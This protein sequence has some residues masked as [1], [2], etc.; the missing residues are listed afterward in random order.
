MLE[1]LYSWKPPKALPHPYL[2]F[3]EHDIPRL[4][5]KA[6]RILGDLGKYSD[7]VKKAI[8][9]ALKEV[10]YAREYAHY[11]L[12]AAFLY[13]LTGNVELADLSLKLV[14]PILKEDWVLPPHRPLKVDLGVAG[15]AG[16]LALI[17]DWLWHYMDHDHREAIKVALVEKALEPFREISSKRLEWWSLSRYNWRSVICGNM[18]LAALSLLGE[19]EPLKECLREALKGVLAVFD[20]IGEDGGYAEG[21][22]YWGYGIGQGIKFVEAL[23]RVSGGDINLYEHPKLHATGYFALYMYTPD[24][25]CFNFSD[26]RYAPPLG[27]L[28]AKLASEYKDEYL[29]W[30][31]EKLRSSD[32]LY[33]I[34]YDER[35]KARRPELPTHK[36]FHS[37]GVA[38]SRSGWNDDDSYLGFRAGPLAVP[39][40]HLDVNSF[41]FY[42][43]GRRL[44]KDLGSW[45]YTPDG[46]LGFFDVRERRW[47]Y[48]AN[49]S[50]GH[51]TLLV[52]GQGQRYD[53]NSYG[54]VLKASFT[55]KVDVIVGE[56]HNAYGGLLSR[57]NRWLIFIKPHILV[58]VDDVASSE[59]HYFELLFH[60]DGELRIEDDGFVIINDPA[61]LR[62]LFLKP[63]KE[64]PKRL[65][66]RISRSFYLSRRGPTAQENEYISISPLFRLREYIFVTIMYAMKL[67]EDINLRAELLRHSRHN[68]IIRL[69]VDTYSVLLKLNLDLLTAHYELSECTRTSGSRYKVYSAG[70]GV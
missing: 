61:K 18:G 12:K 27:W 55:D 3:S 15:I 1:L 29:Q 37:I 38:V 40:S 23:K 6:E 24:G 48:E 2:L 67:D 65:T 45:P 50:L 25:K 54:R 41:V 59:P 46:G 60:P 13:L 19:Y 9:R 8:E 64:D 21:V 26:C 20:N 36:V 39:H 56:G 31:A 62:V 32:I 33:I 70:E 52:D 47:S 66:H 22:G 14:K 10:C 49:S 44:L 7:M 28:V 4:K 69:D 34:F 16:G 53:S 57:F 35:L 58:I 17:Y 42:A 68:L 51:N 11:A 5:D 63:G 30:L 43:Y